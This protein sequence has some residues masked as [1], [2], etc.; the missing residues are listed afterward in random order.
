MSARSDALHAELAV[1]EAEDKFVALKEKYNDGNATEAAYQKA[2]HELRQLRKEHRELVQ[3]N[4][5]VAVEAV[6]AS[7]AV[8]DT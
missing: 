2:K 3:A 4:I 5:D 8:Q 6:E 1:L 7:A